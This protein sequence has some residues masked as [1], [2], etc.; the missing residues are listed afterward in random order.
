VIQL[1]LLAAALVVYGS[2]YP[3][4]FY[5]ARGG[6]VAPWLLLHS[7]PGELNR[8]V[9]RDI[10]L[11]IILYLPIGLLAFVVLSR[12]GLNAG[13][14][15]LACVLA[16]LL[17]IGMEILQ[18]YVPGRDPSILDV[19]SNLL[20]GC[21]GAL[22][23]LLYRPVLEK[24]LQRPSAGQG[25]A[26]FLLA[27]WAISRWYP[28]FPAL[29]RHHLAEIAAIFRNTPVAPI[30]VCHSLAVWFAAV[31]AFRT[32]AGR[33]RPLELL[34]AVAALAGGLFVAGRG[35]TASDAA[36]AVLAI[37]L[38]AALPENRRPSVALALLVIAIAA[39]EL[40]PFH[41]AAA[42]SP[43]WWVP[44]AATFQ[45]ERA[46]AVAVLAGKAFDYGMVLWL[47]RGRHSGPAW[48]AS[49]FAAALLACEMAQR[50]VPGRIP[51]ITDSV[52]VLLLAIVLQRL[53]CVLAPGYTGSQVPGPA[54]LL[55]YF[56]L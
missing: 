7:W 38:W 45:S 35:I 46:A 30:D 39:R 3:W 42:A 51:E 50:Y 14:F 31:L 37:L 25:S 11:N 56:L 44:F 53:E 6:S 34:A 13:A 12:R 18:V 29:S 55:H 27:L 33:S 22:L 19:A 43:F 41:F 21:A 24:R 48:S 54:R 16:F 40:A 4:H 8:F 1:L 28:F 23:G 47:L 10:A 9:M 32:V 36:G 20:G 2:L 17:S 5:F 49:G 26:G 52:L 15:A